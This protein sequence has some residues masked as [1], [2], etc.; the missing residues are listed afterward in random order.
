M[1]YIRFVINNFCKELQVR[2]AEISWFTSDTPVTTDKYL[3]DR[4]MQMQAGT[5]KK[6]ADKM[7]S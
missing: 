4:N 3:S 2:C 5:N 6:H 7:P 1:R